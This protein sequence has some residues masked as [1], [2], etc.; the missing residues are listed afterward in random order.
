MGIFFASVN[1]RL[2]SSNITAILVGVTATRQRLISTQL[3]SIELIFN[4]SSYFVQSI[5]IVI[6]GVIDENFDMI[7]IIRSCS[8]LFIDIQIDTL[9]ELLNRAR[10]RTI[11]RAVA[12]LALGQRVCNIADRRVQ[13]K[14]APATV[15]DCL[16]SFII[17]FAVQQPSEG[18]ALITCTKNAR[19]TTA[20]SQ[21]ADC[22]DAGQRQGKNAFE[23][24]WTLFTS[25]R[26]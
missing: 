12:N 15:L 14:A 10:N 24:H 2:I 3:H 1:S 9:S 20:S 21:H 25:F 18:T 19:A 22:Q 13:I 26:R 11:R 7:T 17:E 16:S 23:F 5:V 6:V 4:S 8:P